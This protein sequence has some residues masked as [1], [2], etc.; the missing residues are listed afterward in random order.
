MPDS[1]ALSGLYLYPVQVAG[2]FR[3][4]PVLEQAGFWKVLSRIFPENLASLVLCRRHGF[5]EVGRYHRHA[6]LDGNWRDVI[7]VERLL[8][9]A[10]LP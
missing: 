2:A 6:Q 3:F 1:V 10:A 5:R 9:A 8:G 7:I 4:L